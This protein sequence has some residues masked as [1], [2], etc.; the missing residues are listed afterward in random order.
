MRFNI[1]KEYISVRLSSD[2]LSLVVVL[3][4]GSIRYKMPVEERHKIIEVGIN[5]VTVTLDTVSRGT[6]H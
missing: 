6:Q 3:S 5:S 1:P 2:G 4:T